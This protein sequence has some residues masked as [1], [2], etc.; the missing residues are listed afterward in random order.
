M[1]AALKKIKAMQK[2]FILLFLLTST[3]YS[4]AQSY[5]GPESVE[6][7]VANGRYL[8]SCK[9]TV[10]SIQQVVPPNAPTLFTSNVTAPYGIEILGSKLWVCDGGRMKS[11]D[12]ATAALVD[13]INLGAT[14]LNGITND[15]VQFLF[16]S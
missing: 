12:L 13:N 15:G 8:V 9:G 7:D 5:S 11:Y 3:L 10:K 14:F 1:F 2:I 16:V 6:Y 4:A